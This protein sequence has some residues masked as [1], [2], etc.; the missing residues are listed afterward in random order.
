MQVPLSVSFRNMAR[1]E[2]I[3][4]ACWSEAEKLER[5]CDRITS[6]RVTITRGKRRHRG[7]QF[8]IHVRCAVPLGE[9]VVSRSS[10]EHRSYERSELTVREVF[11]EVRR[12][13]QDHMRCLRG[14]TKRHATRDDRG[15]APAPPTEAGPPSP[16][17]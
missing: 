10:P 13:L 9:V 17:E 16:A 12:Q 7:N 3:R 1:D 15:G 6:C 5:Y 2:S 14:D 8:D 11:D 4:S